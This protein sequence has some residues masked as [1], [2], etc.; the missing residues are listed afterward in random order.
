MTHQDSLTIKKFQMKKL[1]TLVLMFSSALSFA[2]EQ[3]V[4]YKSF[5]ELS[6]SKGIRG[7]I[8]FQ[9]PLTAKRIEVEV[10]HKTVIH[11]PLDNMPCLVPDVRGFNMPVLKLHMAGSMPVVR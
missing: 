3:K 5:Y 11:L 2:Q 6:K 10:Q 4:P 8:D 1:L 7:K 9:F